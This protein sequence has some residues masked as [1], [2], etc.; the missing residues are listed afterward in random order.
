MERVKMKNTGNF[1]RDSKSHID[2]VRQKLES[3]GH[4]NAIQPIEIA[5]KNWGNAMIEKYGEELCNKTRSF[6]A[7]AGT[8]L[9]QS[10]DVTDDFK[11]KDGVDFLEGLQA[12]ILSGLK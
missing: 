7:I 3:M 1:V 12:R 6:S 5:R 8:S 2:A 9:S 4:A 10:P 11:D